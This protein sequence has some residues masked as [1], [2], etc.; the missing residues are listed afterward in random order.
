MPEN[1]IVLGASSSLSHLWSRWLLRQLAQPPCHETLSTDDPSG[2]GLVRTRRAVGLVLRRSEGSGR[3]CDGRAVLAIV[4]QAHCRREEL[5][6]WPIWT[7]T[8]SRS[9][10]STTPKSLRWPRSARA[11]S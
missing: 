5:E 9:P 1:R 6:P 3:S 8:R 10:R 11:G 7:C 4:R 2:D